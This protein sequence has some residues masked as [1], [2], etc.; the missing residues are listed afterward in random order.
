MQF[1]A[2]SNIW[3]KILKSHLGLISG[4]ISL[5]TDVEINGSGQ[6][7]RIAIGK[8]DFMAEVTFRTLSNSAGVYPPRERRNSFADVII[9][10]STKLES[11][12]ELTTRIQWTPVSDFYRSNTCLLCQY[13]MKCGGV[14][15]MK[16]GEMKKL[17]RDLLS[18]KW[19]NSKICQYVITSWDVTYVSS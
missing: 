19:F 3:E 14:C 17:L 4:S 13:F 18:S 15:E 6:K 8:E 7:A 12:T 16:C 9:T 10:A 2:Y 5:W 11:Q 1:L